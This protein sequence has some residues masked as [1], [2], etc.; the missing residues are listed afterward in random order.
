M[1]VGE[2]IPDSVHIDIS[3]QEQVG[4]LT[5]VCKELNLPI[6]MHTNELVGH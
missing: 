5:A 4:R 1:G 2:V 3:D 6:L